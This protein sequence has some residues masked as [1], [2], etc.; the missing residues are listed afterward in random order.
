LQRSARH[1]ASAT[2]LEQ[3]LAVGRAAVEFAVA[4]ENAVMPVIER[5]SDSPYRWRI[6]KA[7]LARIANHEKKL[8]A[9]FIRSDGYGITARARRYL[10]PLIVGEAWPPFAHGLPRYAN[11]KLELAARKLPPWRAG[12]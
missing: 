4:G 10:A 5:T 11:L 6:G 7:P 1:L 3:A 12:G 2:D 8:P 9:S